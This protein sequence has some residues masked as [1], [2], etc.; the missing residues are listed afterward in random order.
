MVMFKVLSLS[1]CLTFA[2]CTLMRDLLRGG[3][4][5]NGV[6]QDYDLLLLF[7][8][9]V[10]LFV[11]LYNSI[12]KLQSVGNARVQAN[13]IFLA[14]VIVILVLPITKIDD[15]KDSKFEN[16]RL[17]AKPTL[18]SNDS[19]NYEYGKKFEAWLSD[20]FRG[21]ERFFKIYNSI[22]RMLSY[23]LDNKIALEGKDGWLF[24]KG[25]SSV[26]NYQNLNNFS[27]DQLEYIK[28][29]LEAKRDYCKSLGIDYYV[30]IAPDKNQVYP[31]YF[32][33]EYDRI[34]KENRGTQLYNYLKNNS[35]I[36]IA[37]PL[38]ELKE[39]KNHYEVYYRNDTH[40]NSVGAY[41]GYESLF[42][43]IKKDYNSLEKQD[44]KDFSIKR[45]VCNGDLQNMLQLH[46]RK[47]YT[48]TTTRLRNNNYKQSNPKKIEGL[49]LPKD[50]QIVLTDGNS[51]YSV[52][53]FRDS[54][55]TA[56]IPYIS[57]QFGHVEYFWTRDFE[58]NKLYLKNKRPNIVIEECVERYIQELVW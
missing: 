13:I 32:P 5:L 52:I 15:K 41:Y 50:S 23:R 12:K 2:G 49:T 24:Y 7:S 1:T 10:V 54:F 55:S 42:T 39:A 57:Y 29:R 45:I 16:R 58:N 31:E 18:Y 36:N 47:Y 6:S 11:C 17:N 53:L 14:L 37:Y 48:F 8:F 35:T 38:S 33:E 30:L 56:L 25:D 51:P 34:G 19:F 46:E 22:D 40:W 21:R 20:H 28:S 26:K 44:L 27:V 3:R 43:L 4:Q 9:A